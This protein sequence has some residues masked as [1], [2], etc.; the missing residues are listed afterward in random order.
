MLYLALS[1]LQGRL[2]QEAATELLSL[3][4][5]NLQLTPGLVPT[6]CFQQWLGDRD[7][8]YLTHH[9]FSWNKYNTCVWNETASCL[10]TS[11]SIHP[12]LLNSLSGKLWQ[13][14]AE[15]GDYRHLVLE[16]MYPKYHLGNSE[17]LTWAMDEGFKLAVDVSHIYIQLQSGSL[18]TSVWQR[19]QR[20]EQIKELHLSSNNGRVDIH[21]PLTKNSFGLDWVRERGKDN[22]PV[23]LECYMHKLS[24][25]ERLEQIELIDL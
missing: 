18:S 7:I 3:G 1:C 10:V 8:T 11:N 19:L 17:D 25:Q 14:K 22:I 21:K 24:N 20:Y 23:V 2:M 12:P 9:G 16:T 13:Q 6:A 4:I 15:N 5:S